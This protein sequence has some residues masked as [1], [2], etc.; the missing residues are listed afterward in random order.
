M[1][2]K[3]KIM[4]W[5][6]VG[7]VVLVGI[8]A[9]TGNK[10]VAAEVV[11]PAPPSEVW[12]ALVDTSKYGEWHPVLVEAEGT[13]AADA[14]MTY[15]MADPG[16]GKTS[17]VKAKVVRFEPGK[18]LEQKGG[19]PG[20]LTF[21]H[22]WHLEPEGNGTRIKQFEIYGGAWVWFWDPTPVG[23]AYAKANANL[24]DRLSKK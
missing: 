19:V 6:I 10:R 14:T 20:I 24:L 17:P 2:R 7:L 8:A 18:A 1:K 4:L 11:V 21:H 15:Q 5:T 3:T 16:S 13:F 9:L 22:H 12:A 23:E